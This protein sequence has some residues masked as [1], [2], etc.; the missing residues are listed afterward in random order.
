M[1]FEI[2]PYAADLRAEWDEVVDAS[3]NG[4]FLHRR[5]FM[6][7]HAERFTDA[8]LIVRDEDA[9]AVAVFPANRS[10]SGIASHGGLTYG[11]LLYSPR[12]RQ[13]ACL[14]VLEA[15][16]DHYRGLGA[17]DLV[18]KPVP[19]VFRRTAGEEDL[20]ALSRCGGRLIRRDVS[21]VVDL[22]SEYHFTKG[23]TWAA[24]KGRKAGIR[25]ARQ[26]DP[27]QFHQLLTEALMRHGA[28]A[29]HSVD[30]LR[31]LMARFPGEIALFEARME[32]QLL[33]GALLFDTGPAVH[34]QYLA[35][36]AQGREQGALDFLVAEL[37]RTTYRE[38]RYFSF[39]IS[40][41]QGGMVLNEGLIAQ[42]EGFGGRSRC[43]D[44]YQVDLPSGKP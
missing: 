44:W 30:E 2:I 15:I 34:T 25:L 8:S 23:R 42:K 43:H 20:Y 27:A 18:Y 38:R 7:Y 31:L 16:L 29:V 12:L 11:G 6:E 40:T 10:G 33:A 1:A 4:T 5:N 37:M 21:T 36:S 28:S 35:S 9:K 32:D 17:A 24:N 41:E 13:A 26:D 22:Q 39:G 14:E 19:G 3:C